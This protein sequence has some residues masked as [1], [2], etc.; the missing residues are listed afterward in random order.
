MGFTDNDRI[1]IE[2]L[3]IFNNYGAEKLTKVFPDKGWAFSSLKK[4]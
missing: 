1:L 3:Y 4:L 2:N